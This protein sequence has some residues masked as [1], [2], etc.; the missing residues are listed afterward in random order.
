MEYRPLDIT[1]VSAKDLKDV[2]LISKM[3][4][5]AVVSLGGDPRTTQRT[6][7]D[8]EGGKNPTWNFPMKYSVD[9]AA[10]QQNRLSLR[11]LIRAERGLGDRDVGEVHVQIKELLDS[12]GSG[13]VP[14]FVSYQVRRPSGR[15]KG[16]LNFSYKFGEKITAPVT[17]QPP[18]AAHVSKSDEPVMAYP[19]GPSSAYPY[20]P[21]SAGPY[22]PTGSYPPPPPPH[23]AGY[24]YGAPP[25]P[26]YGYGNP[27]PQGGY[28][29]PGPVVQ[30]QA[31]PRK[32][33][34]GMGLG[35]GLLG[36]ALGGLIIGDM[37]SDAADYDNGYDGGFD[38]A[39]GFDF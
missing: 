6:L 1:L 37:V 33:K 23:A 28:G 10:A 2:N 19:P 24:N 36:G 31:P 16:V 3:E 14:Q 30:P 35:A 22:P 20:P 11:I 12:P 9:E 15:P 27:A 29:Y 32:N 21:P 7:T 26:P 13:N 18:T 38:D 25:P 34:F 39:G 4:V 5:Y 8:K 17:E